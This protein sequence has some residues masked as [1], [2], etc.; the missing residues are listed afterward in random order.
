MILSANSRETPLLMHLWYGSRYD[1]YFNDCSCFISIS[2]NLAIMKN[3]SD[4]E[5]NM[6]N[7]ESRLIHHD[8][9]SRSKVNILKPSRYHSYWYKTC[10]TAKTTWLYALTSDIYV[11]DWYP[12]AGLMYL[13]VLPEWR[14]YVTRALVLAVLRTFAC[15]QYFD[16]SN[17][18]THAIRCVSTHINNIWYNHHV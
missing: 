10:I 11:F 5:L 16:D 9:S 14:P 2:T 7:H 3:W 13:R 6:M 17:D 4:S 18:P 8:R 15:F 1:V 12:G